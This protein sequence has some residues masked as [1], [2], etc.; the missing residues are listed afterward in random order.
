MTK[1]R[2]AAFA[3]ALLVVSAPDMM[4]RASVTPAPCTIWHRF[5]PGPIVNGHRRQPTPAEVEAR[6]RELEA[7]RKK[8]PGACPTAPQG[9]KSIALGRLDPS[10]TGRP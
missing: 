2:L 6:L 5:V 8:N 9:A 10:S 3:I 1:P 7:L 4:A